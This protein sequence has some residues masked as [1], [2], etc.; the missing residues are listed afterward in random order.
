VVAYQ[1]T[2]YNN[3]YT[4]QTDREPSTAT[5]Y[6]MGDGGRYV[7][8][9][10]NKVNPSPF[11][12][13]FGT[14]V[15]ATDPTTVVAARRRTLASLNG[16]KGVV[17][18]ALRVYVDNVLKTQN[19][20]AGAG[21]ATY[22]DYYLYSDAGAV[23]TSTASTGFLV[24][25]E[26][27]TVIGVPET[28]T[29]EVINSSTA[30]IGSG[31][32]ATVD[33]YADGASF[34]SYGLGDFADYFSG[35]FPSNVSFYEGRL[36]FSGFSSDPLLVIFSEIGDKAKPGVNYASFQIDALAT[37]TDDPVD[38]GLNSR[39]DDF[40]TGLVNWQQS[41][42]VFTRQAV[43]K[44][45]GGQNGFSSTSKFSTRI[46][47][48]GLVNPYGVTKSDRSILYLSDIGVFDLFLSADGDNY[49]A[50]EKSIKIRP[51]FGITKTPNRESLAWMS[52]D[53][54][55]Q[56]IYVGLPITQLDY[57]SFRMYVYST[58]RESWT[59]YETPGGWNCY[60]CTPFSD[61]TSG[62]GY[63]GSV[64]TKRDS[65]NIPTNRMFIQYEDSKY[66]DFRTISTG[67]GAT[68]SYTLPFDRRLVTHTTI[69][70]VYEYGTS[71]EQTSS[72]FGFQV[73]PITNVQD[74]AVQIEM[75][76]GGGIYSTLTLGTDYV[77]RP[78]GKIYL[79]QNPGS[80][81]NL[82]IYQRLPVTDSTQGKDLFETA[83]ALAIQDSIAV[84]IDN[85]LQSYGADFTTTATS[86]YTLNFVVAPINNSVV[87]YGRVYQAIYESPLLTFSDLSVRKRPRFFYVYF[88]NLLGSDTFTTA[89]L[90]S[91]TSPTQ[92][93]ET[94][95]GDFKQRLN[96]TI[97]VAYEA[98]PECEVEYDLYGFQNLVF[99]DSLFDIYPTANQFRRYTCFKEYLLGTGYGH[100]LLVFSFDDSAFTLAGYQV[101]ADI[102]AE[103][104]I[105]WSQ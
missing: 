67:N 48:I 58:F 75:I 69:D 29:I 84:N 88:D 74:V 97:A 46:S 73:I 8:A 36:V 72:R 87:E 30:Y 47:D 95:V 37:D 82:R 27:A 66:I 83:S 5:Q 1:N 60:Y 10:G 45:I 43:F 51:L 24:S 17:G 41:L 50:S 81:R 19:T 9:A 39:P 91:A 65:S 12:F 94:I 6:A 31:A 23:L 21:S 105:N 90:N 7:N 101:T 11:F 3:T 100:Q 14:I 22:G 40:V 61:R 85:V 77:K 86:T 54:N 16:G 79:I 33:S 99:D 42:F 4:Y 25:F 104:Y 53:N 32:T 103:R 70:K 80:G 71:T 20:N 28:A 78:N 26:A 18:T 89:D 49:E 2:V 13:T 92:S 56:K 57:T 76:A 93:V 68:T 102:K 15:G 38:I 35:S 55:A 62:A 52:Y 63:L 34:P 59:E 96:A 98:D 44:I 64:V